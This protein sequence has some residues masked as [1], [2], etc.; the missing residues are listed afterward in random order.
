MVE[1]FMVTVER[2]KSKVTRSSYYVH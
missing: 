1:N 2:P